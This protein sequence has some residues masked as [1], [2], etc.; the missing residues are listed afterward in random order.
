[1]NYNQL[2]NHDN[3]RIATR[4]PG[5]SDQM[6]FLAMILPGIAITYYGEEI[7]MEDK[8][9]ITWE[10]TQDPQACNTDRDHYKEH[11]RDP[12]R[13]PFQWD[14]SKNAGKFLLNTNLILKG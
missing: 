4:Y 12:N 3:G 14:D 2:G 7:G 8:L 13:T 5:R 1:M 11:T 10:A 9:D 6:I